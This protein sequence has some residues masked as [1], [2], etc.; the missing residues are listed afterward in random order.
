MGLVPPKGL[1]KE[2]VKYRQ[3]EQCSACMHF[4]AMSSSCD[5][6][7]GNISADNVCDRWEIKPPS[8]PKDKAYYEE[9][10]TKMDKKMAPKDGMMM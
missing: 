1:S 6:V 5:I 7:D 4:Y 3:H 9:E 8:K 10:R 2:D